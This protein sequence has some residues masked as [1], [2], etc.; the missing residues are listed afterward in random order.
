MSL[1]HY[2][3]TTEAH[4]FRIPKSSVEDSAPLWENGV[5]LTISKDEVLGEG[6]QI[7]KWARLMQAAAGKGFKFGRLE[8]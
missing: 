8:P 7:Q 1:D 2:V 4:P 5:D 3:F 6:T